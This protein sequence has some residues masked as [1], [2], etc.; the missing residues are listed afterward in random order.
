MKHCP[1]HADLQNMTT[2]SSAVLP[3]R[4]IACYPIE[5][6]ST[7]CLERRAPSLWSYCN[8]PAASRSPGRPKLSS[9]NPIPQPVT[10]TPSYTC[11][12]RIALTDE[13]VS[14]ALL[15]IQKPVTIHPD[16]MPAQRCSLKM[17]IGVSKNRPVQA[18]R[19]G[20]APPST[21]PG[22]AGTQNIQDW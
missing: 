5:T 11:D 8:T 17:R 20:A 15:L 7:T 2:K 18:P 6:L 16:S 19:R 13:G 21:I 3:D 1:G 9:T 10:C 12:P 14:R 4:P 22:S